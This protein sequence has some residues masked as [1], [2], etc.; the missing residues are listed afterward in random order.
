MV[1]ILQS[2]L[3]TDQLDVEFVFDFE[4]SFEEE[5]SSEDNNSNQDT[6]SQNLDD[7]SQPN[8]ESL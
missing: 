5:N 8:E 3:D 2:K 4:K 1:S 6:Q 7:D